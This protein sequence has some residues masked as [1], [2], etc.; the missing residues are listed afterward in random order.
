MWLVLAKAYWKVTR[1]GEG[2]CS[3]AKVGLS[4][5]TVRPSQ[6]VLAGRTTV[7]FV[8][9]RGLELRMLSNK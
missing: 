8:P 7:F 1:G 5:A 4:Y 6:N 3:E 2:L 9:R